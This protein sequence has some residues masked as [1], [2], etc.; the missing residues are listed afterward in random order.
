MIYILDPLTCV[1]LNVLVLLNYLPAIFQSK[2]SVI[3][4]FGKKMRIKKSLK[5]FKRVTLTIPKMMSVTKHSS[6]NFQ[7]SKISS[8]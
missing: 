2:R 8:V 4:R 6:T 3:K 5:N 1:Y 7:K